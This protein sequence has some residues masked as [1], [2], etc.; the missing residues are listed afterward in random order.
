MI[1]RPPVATLTSRGRLEDNPARARESG[2]DQGAIRCP[3]SGHDNREEARF[4]D[5]CGQPVS[6]R[7]S[8]APA[9]DLRA[10]APQHLDATRTR[11]LR[12]AHRL[13]TEMG[14]TGHAEHLA[15][16]LGL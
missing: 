4:C 1:P 3:S 9:R 8:A 5:G 10:N 15:R 7:A 6:G 14:T 11:E 2:V 13:F 16:E 12:E